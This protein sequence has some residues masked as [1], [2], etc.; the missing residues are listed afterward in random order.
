MV[1]DKFYEGL[2]ETLEQHGIKDH[3]LQI[4]NLDET[5]LNTCGSKSGFF[6]RPGV[7]EAHIITPNEG[8]TMYTVLFACNAVGDFI[9][10]YVIYKG[11]HV[12]S[13]W[14]KNGPPGTSYNNTDSGWME[15]YVFESWFL[16]QFIKYTE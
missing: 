10:P 8:K 2:G 5:G 6:F 1:R 14:V 11:K 7:K 15:D 13:S 16:K 4:F 9:P 3:R 12:H